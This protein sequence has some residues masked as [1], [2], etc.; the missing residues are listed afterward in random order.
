MINVIS[1]TILNTTTRNAI[2]IHVHT[3]LRLQK[4]TLMIPKSK[5]E[6]KTYNKVHTLVMVFAFTPM[7]KQI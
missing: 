7:P 1:L 3:L 4:M 6:N 5:S 2:S